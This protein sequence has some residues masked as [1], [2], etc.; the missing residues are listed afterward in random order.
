MR[1]NFA[2]DDQVYTVDVGEDMVNMD[3]RSLGAI[4]NF[5]T[6]FRKD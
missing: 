1:L 5:H 4:P 3:Q 2:S 6:S